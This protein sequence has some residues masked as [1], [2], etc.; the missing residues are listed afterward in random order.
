[1]SSLLP[2]IP[3]PLATPQ[4]EQLPITPP[5]LADKPSPNVKL[6]TL[7][8]I[9]AVVVA[10]GRLE[11]AI[12]DLIWT[13]DGKT[14]SNGRF[15]TQELDISKLLSALQRSVST[16]MPGQSLQNER[17]AITNLIT[18]IN[19]FKT[20]R[21]RVVHGTWAE[22]NNIPV[23]G[24]LRFETTHNDFVTFESYDHDRLRV[25]EQVARDGTSTVGMFISRIE[26]LR[27]TLFQ[28]QQT[29]QSKNPSGL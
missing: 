3:P 12:N 13:I 8:R 2:P 6:S 7:R 17:K 11:N 9:G 10:W 5:N 20:Y 29:E 15:D 24:S 26:S 16:K 27:E 21:N 1:M 18:I 19:E 22:L 23:V 4:I 25:I 28:Q 14:I